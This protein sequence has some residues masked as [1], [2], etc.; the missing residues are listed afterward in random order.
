MKSFIFL[1]DVTRQSHVIAK[2]NGHVA[3]GHFDLESAFAEGA[4]H[5]W[6]L[7]DVDADQ[8]GFEWHVVETLTTQ[9]IEIVD[10]A[11]LRRDR[12]APTVTS[13]DDRVVGAA[14]DRVMGI[15]RFG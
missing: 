15:G 14:R 8:F 7:L 1:I 6:R 4:A 5:S 11:A 13:S 10:I 2:E 3:V 9:M 12:D